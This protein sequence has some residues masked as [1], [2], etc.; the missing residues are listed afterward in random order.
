MPV[1][2]GQPDT[3]WHSL[4]LVRKRG[5]K[6]ACTATT[7]CTR[8]HA[9]ASSGS[10]GPS[11]STTDTTGVGSGSQAAADPAAPRLHPCGSCVARGSQ[12]GGA[13]ARPPD[14]R[15]PDPGPRQAAR[16]AAA[17]TAAANAARCGAWPSAHR[18]SGLQNAPS[19]DGGGGTEHKMTSAAGGHPS[20]VCIPRL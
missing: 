14:D 17:R 4:V 3:S 9:A 16:S 10:I 8:P 15:N 6:R 18:R 2:T 12:C 11:P 5:L 7:C 1:F 20:R 13:A 19:E